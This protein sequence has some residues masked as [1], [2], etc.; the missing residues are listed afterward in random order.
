MTH[1]LVLGVGVAQFRL[2][3][4]PGPGTPGA[5]DARTMAELDFIRAEY[6]R[7]FLAAAKPRPAKAEP[8]E[9]R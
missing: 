3:R 6:N 2:V 9:R 4:L 7:A 8:K 1:E 5:Q